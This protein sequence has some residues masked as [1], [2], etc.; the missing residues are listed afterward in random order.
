MSVTQT[1]KGHQGCLSDH[2][3]QRRDKDKDQAA[4][5]GEGEVGQREAGGQDVAGE[6][7]GGQHKDART[8]DGQVGHVDAAR[9]LGVAHGVVERRGQAELAGQTAGPGVWGEG[10]NSIKNLME[11][12]TGV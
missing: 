5:E 9:V 6:R 7:D 8:G 10:G 2:V 12:I 11:I 1:T 3:E 4:L